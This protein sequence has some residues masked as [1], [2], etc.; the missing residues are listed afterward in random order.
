MVYN[1]QALRDAANLE[2][3]RASEAGEPIPGVSI[4]TEVVGG[5]WTDVVLGWVDQN[6][7]LHDRPVF[8]H[9]FQAPL[10]SG[11]RKS[12]HLGKRFKPDPGILLKRV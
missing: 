2:L 3:Q 10:D 8:P 6:D 11:C 4:K 9:L 7:I 5:D 12:G 1:E